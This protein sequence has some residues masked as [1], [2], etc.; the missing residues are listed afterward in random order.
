MAKKKKYINKQTGQVSI[1]EPNQNLGTTEEFKPKT[2]SQ[3]IGD[4]KL[5]K[6]EYDIA[7]NQLG[8][9][10]GK[11]GTPN[12]NVNKAVANVATPQIK[13]DIANNPQDFG[14]RTPGQEVA[15]PEGFEVTTQQAG[16]IENEL[17]TVQQR[18][19]DGSV[20]ETQLPYATA[21][22]L[23]LYSGPP[24]SVE[25]K[26]NIAGAAL[27]AGVLGGPVALEGGA[28]AWRVGGKVF[29]NGKRAVQAGTAAKNAGIIAKITK[30]PVSSLVAAYAG[31][32]TFQGVL[33]W[34]GR[35]EKV[36][37][38]QQA[39]NTIG[40]MATT[41]GGQATEAS[42]DWRKG[43]QELDYLYNQ[44]E[45]L[46]V[47]IQ[48]GKIASAQIRYDGKIYDITADIEDQLRTIDEQRSIIRS[49]VLT[50]SFPELSDLEIQDYLRELEEEGVIEPVDLTKER[51][52]TSQL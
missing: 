8:F 13:K 3:Q 23:G 9:S 20:V 5:T 11:G 47:L 52:N 7:K 35:T 51:R 33:N 31:F 45:E 6:E 50:N 24:P 21:V 27:A 2:Q 44:V 49:F 36:E 26:S 32:K 30:D 43:L 17:V 42:G 16:G 25:R 22:S 10:T 14:L 38:Q 4:T 34:L 18:R 19:E 15:T 1:G 28:T 46:S 37:G 12:A 40:Q 41:I 29:T 48:Q 39:L